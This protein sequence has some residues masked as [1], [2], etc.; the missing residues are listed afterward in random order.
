MDEEELERYLN[1]DEIREEDY[2][3]MNEDHSA[4][5]DDE[6]SPYFLGG[7]KGW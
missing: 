2:P 7:G 6:D 4:D 5:F 1:D 3:W